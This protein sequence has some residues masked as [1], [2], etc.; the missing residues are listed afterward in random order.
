M[1]LIFLLKTM[2]IFARAAA[3][4]RGFAGAGYQR[5]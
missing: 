1:V 3:T 5:V 4:Q 2:R